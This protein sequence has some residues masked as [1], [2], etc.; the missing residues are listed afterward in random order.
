MNQP[1]VVEKYTGEPRLDAVAMRDNLGVGNT[2]F[3]CNMTDLFA[4]GVPESAVD[5]ILKKCR[6]NRDNIYVF[7]TKN[8]YQ[9]RGWKEKLPSKSILGTT[10][11]TNRDSPSRAPCPKERMKYLFRKNDGQ[12]FVTVEP[13]LAFDPDEMIELLDHGDS[14]INIGADS[15]GNMMDEPVKKDV[16]ELIRELRRI[17][18]DVRI[19]VNLIKRY[20]GSL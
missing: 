4:W 1:A 12:T 13:I 2:I 17:G 18:Y 6:E 16:E 8:T 11:E 7:Q 20:G 14:F 19:K 5:A 10:V 9:M 15:C 3:V